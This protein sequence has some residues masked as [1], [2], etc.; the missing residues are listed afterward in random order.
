MGSAGLQADWGDWC[1]VSSDSL[2]VSPLQAGSNLLSFCFPLKG[3]TRNE[4]KQ[5]N[6]LVLVFAI[7]CPAWIQIMSFEFM[8]SR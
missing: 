3:L 4:D 6:A 2:M 7:V 8:F 5:V 1:E